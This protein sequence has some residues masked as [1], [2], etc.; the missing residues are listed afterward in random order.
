MHQPALLYYCHMKS[1]FNFSSIKVLKVALRGPPQIIPLAT[2]GFL[3]VFFFLYFLS[4]EIIYDHNKS[5]QTDLTQ[6]L[7]IVLTVLQFL[8]HMDFLLLVHFDQVLLA[9]TY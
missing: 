1:S 5:A 3:Y 2:K 7:D 8:Y 9:Q 6:Y 4:I